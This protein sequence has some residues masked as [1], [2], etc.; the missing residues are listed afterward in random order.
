MRRHL[1]VVVLAATALLAATAAVAQAARARPT[2]LLGRAVLPA[3]T[4]APGPPSG[5]LLG[6]TPI[7]GVAVPFAS[8]PVQGF[9]AALPS[10]EGRSWVMADNGYGSIE[11]SADFNLRVYLLAPDLKT[12]FGG[13]GT[14]AVKRFIGL[15]DPDH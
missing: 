15:R 13:A 5:T 10:G 3:R 1:T 7:N 14:I 11:N 6:S 4:F 8:Q 9:S 2:R 12:R